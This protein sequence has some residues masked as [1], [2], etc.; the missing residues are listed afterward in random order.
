MANVRIHA[1]TEESP[2]IRFERDERV[3]LQP[4]AWRPYQS[5][6]LLPDAP[7]SPSRPPVP[8]VPVERRPRS[9]AGSVDC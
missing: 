5:L 9:K 1:T 8:R 4:A 2:R 7:P 6:V 3:H